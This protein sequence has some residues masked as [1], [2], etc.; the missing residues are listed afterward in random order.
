M[1]LVFANVWQG[2]KSI[3]SSGKRLTRNNEQSS[4]IVLLKLIKK[5]FYNKNVN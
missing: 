5:K 1:I 2:L 3:E 4:L